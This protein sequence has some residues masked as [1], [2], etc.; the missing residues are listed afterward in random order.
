M[1][2]AIRTVS[3]SRRRARFLITALPRRLVA[4]NPNRATRSSSSVCVRLRACN[5]RLPARHE[6]PP[7]TRKNS[8]RFFNLP[9]VMGC[10]LTGTVFLAPSRLCRQF[11]AALCAAPCQNLHSAGCCL[12]RAETVP[13]F[14]HED[15]WLICAFHAVNSIIVQP[16]PIG[17]ETA[18]FRELRRLY[19]WAGVKSIDATDLRSTSL[20]SVRDRKSR[21]SEISGYFP[22]RCTR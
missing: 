16:V 17:Q 18:H 15:A 6:R 11:L 22:R 7:R 2:A 13:P 14:S 12:T 8:A 3:F 19:V 1:L 10:W 4:V 21:C 9:R 5:T 20:P